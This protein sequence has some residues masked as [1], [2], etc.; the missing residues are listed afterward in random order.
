M[1]HTGQVRVWVRLE[2]TGA[3]LGSC[4]VA[5]EGRLHSGWEFG[6]PARAWGLGYGLAGLGRSSRVLRRPW[7]GLAEAGLA[8][9]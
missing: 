1:S 9:K 6:A 4:V 5:S 2:V 3:W 8:E 7:L